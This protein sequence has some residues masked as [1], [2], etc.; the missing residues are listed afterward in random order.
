MDNLNGR[1]GSIRIGTRTFLGFAAVLVLLLAVSAMA[2]LDLRALAEITEKLYRHPFAVTAA[3]QE[4]NA[5]IVSMHRSMKDVALARSA[6]DIDRAARKVS[7]EEAKVLALFDV[8]QERFLGDRALLDAPRSAFLDWRPIRDEVIAQTRAGNAEA[9]ARVTRERGAGQVDQIA[10]GMDGLITFARNRAEAFMATSRTETAG[11]MQQMLI[12]AATAVILGFG[13][14]WLITISLTRPIAALCNVM[15]RL[16]GGDTAVEVLGAERLDELGEMAK[17]VQVFK[18]NAIEVLRLKADEEARTHRAAEEKRQALGELADRFERSV[19]SVVQRVGT[20]ATD[21]EQTAQ[22]LARG[23]EESTRQ[24]TAVAAAAEQASANVQT[25]AAA[26]EELSSSIR[27]ISRQV[28]SSTTV[29]RHASGET[30]RAGQ[31]IASLS[32]AAQK[33]GEV[34]GLIQD[35]AGQTNLLALNATIEAARAGDAGKGFSVVASEVKSLANQT[36]RA[37][38]E[39]AGQVSAIQ[40]VSRDVVEAIRSITG[41]I[42]TIN[43]GAAAIASAVEEQNA[44]TQEI[45]RNVQEAA[46]G[47]D[48]V[49]S[50]ITGVS[51]L[52]GETGDASQQVLSGSRSMRQETAALAEAVEQF[53]ASVRAE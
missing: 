39:I 7:E 45:A 23:S 8:L 18:D 5:R 42:T 4:A 40:V 44:A 11:I 10:R 31:T 29:A 32:Q 33:I 38:E 24:T 37:T 21:L 22:S 43:E 2:V 9:A 25:A 19:K 15:T 51:R 49:S 35:I 36:A 28:S 48:H 6:D 20:A 12:L 3:A 50:N 1:L 13:L 34:I 30:E 52:A 26:A 16:A 53:L 46:T 17:R 41:T 47:T 27:E 14:A